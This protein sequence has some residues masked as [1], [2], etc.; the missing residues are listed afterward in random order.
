MSIGI[1]DIF[2]SGLSTQQ[3]LLMREM[4]LQAEDTLLIIIS[5]LHLDKPLVRY[6]LII[7][8]YLQYF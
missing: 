5:E 2:G 4:E 8:V 6:I 1:D 3:M 7:L